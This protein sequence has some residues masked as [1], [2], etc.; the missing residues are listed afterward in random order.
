MPWSTALSKLPFV[1][2]T[3]SRPVSLNSRPKRSVPG[4]VKRDRW[5]AEALRR[6]PA[7]APRG[8]A[9]SHAGGNGSV[10]N[11]LVIRTDHQASSLSILVGLA[12]I[13]R[14]RRSG[15]V[16]VRN[17][18]R[19]EAHPCAEAEHID[20]V[21]VSRCPIRDLTLRYTCIHHAWV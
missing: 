15:E 16:F 2:L 17:M 14:V 12:N 1:L 7:V 5:R 8:T 18:E 3:G 11:R 20:L 21:K 6:A 4:P 13:Q 9:P 19:F 10:R